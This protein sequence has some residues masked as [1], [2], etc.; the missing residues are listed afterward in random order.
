MLEITSK[1]THPKNKTI[2]RHSPN[3]LNCLKNGFFMHDLV[4]KLYQQV[5]PKTGVRSGTKTKNRAYRQNGNLH[6]S[7]Q[8][9]FTYFT[10]FLY[11]FDE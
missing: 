2:S 8:I 6:V 1:L 4:F 10:N 7:K 5:K 11:F 3:K 9:Y